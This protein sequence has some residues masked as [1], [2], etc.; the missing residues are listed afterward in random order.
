[1]LLLQN[2]HSHKERISCVQEKILLTREKMSWSCLLCAFNSS[3][4]TKGNMLRITTKEDEEEIPSTPLIMDNRRS[5][6]SSTCVICATADSTDTVGKWIREGHSVQVIFIFYPTQRRRG[7]TYVHY[8]CIECWIPFNFPQKNHSKTQ[9]IIPWTKTSQKQFVRLSAFHCWT[10]SVVAY[11]THKRFY[12][13]TRLSSENYP[14]YC[15]FHVIVMFQ[16]TNYD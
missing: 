2:S 3:M 7:R 4:H 16:Q 8:D 5:K 1:M 13:L 9:T 6:L 15:V 14:Y 11:H 12:P 10:N